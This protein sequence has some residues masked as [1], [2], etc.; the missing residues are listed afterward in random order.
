M[1]SKMTKIV[2]KN[3]NLLQN[4]NISGGWTCGQMESRR[5]GTME[6]PLGLRVRV[7]PIHPSWQ[8]CPSAGERRIRVFYLE[9]TIRQPAPL[10][11]SA[12]QAT[13]SYDWTSQVGFPSGERNH[14]PASSH[15]H[16]REHGGS[17]SH[18]TSVKGQPQPHTGHQDSFSC[19][20]VFCHTTN[21]PFTI[22]MGFLR[23][24]ICRALLANQQAPPSVIAYALNALAEEIALFPRQDSS[25]IQNKMRNHKVDF[26]SKFL[27][28]KFSR[29]HNLSYH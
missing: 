19:Q 11:F 25:C 18:S 7:C 23:P 14:W 6:Q 28:Q 24:P 8:V 10:T 5:R 29:F 26:T 27:C 17:L 12:C 20:Q 21:S 13:S 3:D 9:V 16:D 4:V 22:N 1:Q 2:N 15:A